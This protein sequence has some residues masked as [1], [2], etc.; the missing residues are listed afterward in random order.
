[1]ARVTY[2]QV[3]DFIVYGYTCNNNCLSNSHATWAAVEFWFFQFFAKIFKIKNLR[4]NIHWALNLNDK[5]TNEATGNADAERI[6][7][8]AVP[9]EESSVNIFLEI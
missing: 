7:T 2:M 5:A 6:P 8:K 4:F 3:T 1:M 9:V